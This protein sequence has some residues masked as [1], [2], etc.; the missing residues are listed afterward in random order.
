VYGQLGL[1]SNRDTVA[2]PAPGYRSRCRPPGAPAPR[3]TAQRGAP[4][5]PLS[6]RAKKMRRNLSRKYVD[7]GKLP[8]NIFFSELTH[9]ATP[10]V[11]SPPVP[12]SWGSF[13]S[14]AEGSRDPPLSRLLLS[15]PGSSRPPCLGPRPLLAPTS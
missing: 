12:N 14:G 9:S 13:P 4:Q 5:Q 7:N 15:L 8:G 3:A 11:P 6:C 1:L 2:G 10:K